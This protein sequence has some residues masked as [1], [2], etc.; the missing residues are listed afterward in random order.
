MTNFYVCRSYKTEIVTE[1][2]E[3]SLREKYPYSELF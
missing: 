3:L 1:K 2:E